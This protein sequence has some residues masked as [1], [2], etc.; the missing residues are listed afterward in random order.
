METTPVCGSILRPRRLATSCFDIG[1]IFSA[2]FGRLFCCCWELL[3]CRPDDDG[4][5]RKASVV[6]D[7]EDAKDNSNKFAAEGIFIIR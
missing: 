2:F 7:M 4:V 1:S 3:L 5:A 6:V